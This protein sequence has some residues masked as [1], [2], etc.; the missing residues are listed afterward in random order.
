MKTKVQAESSS[1]FSVSKLKYPTYECLDLPPVN[2]FY[3]P[4]LYAFDTNYLDYCNEHENDE[5]NCQELLCSKPSSFYSNLWDLNNK[6]Q[7]SQL[8]SVMNYCLYCERSDFRENLQNCSLF[9][10]NNYTKVLN[11]LNTHCNGNDQAAPVK[12]LAMFDSS[13]IVTELFK[14]DYLNYLSN[15]NL[16]DSNTTKDTYM[17]M[18]N[19]TTI[20][21]YYMDSIWNSDSASWKSTMN[22][23]FNCWCNY[24][25][26]D[27]SYFGF[28][29]S[30]FYQDYQTAFVYRYSV[31]V[32][33]LI[34]ASL[35]VILLLFI[36]IPRIAERI[37]TLKKKLNKLNVETYKKVLFSIRHIF[38]IVSHPVFWLLLAATCG[39]IENFLR[40]IFN[41]N[42]LKPFFDVYFSGLFRALTALCCLCGYSS[43]VILWSHIIDISNRKDG[44]QGLSLY[45]KIILSIFYSCLIVSII[46]ALIVFVATGNYGY[47]YIVLSCAGLVYMMTFTIG[48]S[49]YGVKILVT[50]RKMDDRPVFEY[51]FT[52]FIL[53]V[54]V[55]FIITWIVVLLC[56]ITYSFG[57]DVIGLFFGI[58][59]NIF[60]DACMVVIVAFSSYM[61]FNV[62]AFEIIYGE[63]AS[64]WANNFFTSQSS[65]DD[66]EKPA[67]ILK[68]P[69]RNIPPPAST[70][71]TEVAT[72]PPTEPVMV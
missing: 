69:R 57:F 16:L 13:F 68:T 66:E 12:S 45:N 50:L 65:N 7:R 20:F 63:R 1:S 14:R 15:N 28:T 71:T 32:F 70:S 26:Y 52:K 10:G 17:K 9:G 39:T 58:T 3:Y 49:F 24:Q 18:A 36:S 41:F 53:G 61:T 72:E 5:I 40:F 25:N 60:L 51:R 62:D 38:D 22:L 44:K 4:K 11:L 55:I 30:D 64:K 29:C 43:L 47:A 42:S 56:L 27:N 21:K 33:T 59:R 2:Q 23:P 54:T 31:I 8:D 34:Y 37:L 6:T 67:D 48:F 46:I 19:L 35:F